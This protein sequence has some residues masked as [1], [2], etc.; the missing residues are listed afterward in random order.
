[1]RRYCFFVIMIMMRFIADLQIHSK[2]SRATSS[3][4]VI[5]ELAKWAKIKGIKVIGT[6]DFTHPAWFSELKSKLKPAEPGL[7]IWKDDPNKDPTRFMLTAETSHIY[8]KGGKIRRVHLLIWAPSFEAVEK[9]NTRLSWVGNLES[10]GR[11]VLGMDA[12]ELLKI[13]L[14]ADPNAMVIP[15]HA[16]TPWFSVFGS[17]SGFDSLAECFEELTPHIYAIETGLSCYDAETEVLTENGWKKFSRVTLRDKICTLNLRTEEIE[18]QRPQKIYRS[19]YKGKMYRLKTKRVDLLVTPNHNLVYAPADFHTKRPYRLEEARKLFGKSKILRKDGIWR[20]VTP[21]YFRLPEVKIR[22][23]SR[24]YSGFRTKSAKLLPIKPWL[25]FFGFWLA[26]GWTTEGKDGHYAVCL[27]NR[28]HKLMIEMK[29]ILESFGYSVF[30]DRKTTNTLRVRDYQLFHY[31][32]QFGKASEKYIPPEV[33]RLS[34]ELLTIFFEYY[35]KGDGH[36]YGRSEKGLSATTTSRRLRDDLQEIALKLGMSAYYKLHNK[37]GTPCTF[38]SQKKMYKQNADSWNVYFI[39]RNRHAIIP[40]EMKKYGRKEEW[41][42]YDGMVYCVSVPNRTV[43]IR[44]NGIPLWCGNSDPAMNWR[45]SQLDAVSI[46]SNSDS[47][48]LERIGREANVFDT[49]LSYQEII[50][51]VKSKDPSRFLFTIEFFPEEGKYHY[52]GH[53][54]CGIRLSPEERKKLG[55]KCPKCGR[56]VTV[57]VL[58]R[59]EELAD[60]PPGYIPSGAIPFKSLVPLDEII[61][62][63]LGVESKTKKVYEI[64]YKLCAAFGGEL[65]LLLDASIEDIARLSDSK[66]A[67]GIKRVREG[68]IIAEPGY[69]GEYG[70][71]KVFAEEKTQ[72]ESINQQSLF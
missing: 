22:H 12:K 28:D 69:D 14:D 42:D 63:A 16:W 45:L 9:I 10:D 44:R 51:A 64:Y 48:S 60:R 3:K 47:H 17:M 58:S 57:G 72:K 55:G 54:A 24:F 33:K 56:P 68:K 36:K 62:E 21:Q 61:R 20:G 53:R 23:G 27:A 38:I 11:P 49:E 32:R 15:A 70:K 5:E 37:K 59:V 46:V 71:I 43:Y 29:N 6:G 30:W 7:F 40:S 26:E 39:R 52:D 35:I 1:M 2:Y 34:K 65:P 13:V 41:V 50:E 18:Y 66:I 25:K 31:L 4:M 67:E 19:R 8:S